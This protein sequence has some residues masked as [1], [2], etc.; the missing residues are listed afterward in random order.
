LSRVFRPTPTPFQLGRNGPM[1]SSTMAFRFVCRRELDRVRVFSR[2]GHDSTDRVPRIAE[3]LSALPVTSITIDGEGVACGPDGVADSD[4][5][6]AAV[7]RRGSCE[8]FL[9]AFDLIR[10]RAR[11]FA[12]WPRL[13]R[14][15]APRVEATR[16]R[17]RSTCHH[18]KI[19][20]PG[21]TCC[22][23][24]EWKRRDR[25]FAANLH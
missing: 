3:A 23:A 8:A 21:R 9:Y 22:A 15:R 24:R 11:V 20:R 6:R 5:L 4:L 25:L 16:C 10:S 18:A 7:G 14:S 12:S 13:D 2:R 1:R 19:A 17:C